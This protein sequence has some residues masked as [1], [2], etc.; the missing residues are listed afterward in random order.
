MQSVADFFDAL[1][2]PFTWTRV[3][4][5]IIGTILVYYALVSD[6]INKMWGGA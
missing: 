4:W 1:T 5:V 3:L 2:D 6:T